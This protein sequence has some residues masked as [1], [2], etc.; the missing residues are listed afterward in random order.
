[1]ISDGER[2]VRLDYVIPTRGL[3]EFYSQFLSLTSELALCIMCLI[4][5]DH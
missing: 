3:V 5:M 2:R 1:M 4:I